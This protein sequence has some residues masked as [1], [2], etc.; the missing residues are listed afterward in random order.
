MH[1][2]GLCGE[3][4]SGVPVVRSGRM[5]Y[6][7]RF[8]VRRISRERFYEQA[9][10]FS[11]LES[12]RN[13]KI[14]TEAEELTG[15]ELIDYVNSHQSLWKAK[16]NRRF[17]RYP[18]RTKWGLMGVNHVRLSVMAKQHL[19]TTK[20]LDIYIPES[21]DSREEWPNCESIKVIRDQSSC[22]SCWAFGAVEA[23]SDRICIAS[24]GEIQ[25]SLSAD[26]LL[27]CCKSCGFGC[28]GG[29]PLAAWKY[30]V[31]D[32][33]VTGSNFTANQGCKPYPFPPCEHHSNKTHYDPCRHDLFPTPKCEK[34]CVPTYNEKSYNE[35]K[36]YGTFGVF[37][38]T[39]AKIL[40]FQVG[41][42]DEAQICASHELPG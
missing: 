15:K 32:G 8:V 27:S 37:G 3:G 1:R 39:D 2:Q 30:W 36:Y 41:E 24:K 25:V 26:D 4:L 38:C 23:M 31:R 13:R 20:D 14:P 22:G 16:E 5:P 33:I 10:H 11:S 12:F 35:D 9:V 40:D 42:R 34:K 28:N 18:D 29:D 7:N 19:S 17:A 6:Q 21:F